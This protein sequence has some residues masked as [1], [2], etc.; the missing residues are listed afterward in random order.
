MNFLLTNKSRD[1]HLISPDAAAIPLAA[2][3][4][5]AWLSAFVSSTTLW[6]L[7]TPLQFSSLLPR[8]E[9]SLSCCLRVSELSG[10]WEM[11][12]ECLL[13]SLSP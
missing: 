11:K 2:S 9:L 10:A 4:T 3:P 5:S 1:L 7:Q 13:V 12:A 8:P 6:R